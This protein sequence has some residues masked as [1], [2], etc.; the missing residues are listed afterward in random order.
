MRRIN[1]KILI[2]TEFLILA[3]YFYSVSFYANLQVASI[4]SFIIML[5]SF[6]AHSKM[7]NS[8]VLTQSYESERDPLDT[9]DDPHELY[10]DNKTV[11]VDGQ[12]FKQIIKDEKKKIKTFSFKSVKD[13]SSATFSLFRLIGYLFLILGFIALKNNEILQISVYLPSLLVGIIVG[14]IVSRE[15]FI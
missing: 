13:S 6:Y 8:K 10:D 12:D 11:E 9:I 14:Y 1:I 7:V 15:I 4:S 3:T 2:I 5:A